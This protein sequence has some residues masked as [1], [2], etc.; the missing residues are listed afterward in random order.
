MQGSLTPLTSSLVHALQTMT[1]LMFASAEE[2]KAT[3]RLRAATASALCPTAAQFGALDPVRVLVELGADVEVGQVGKLSHRPL[4]EAAKRGHDGGEGAAGA[5]C[6][7]FEE[8][9]SSTTLVRRCTSAEPKQ[10]C[11]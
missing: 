5:G 10:E 1:T 8:H 11:G 2:T 4:H 3:W 6:G 7:L 9:V